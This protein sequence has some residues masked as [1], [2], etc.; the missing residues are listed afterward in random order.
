MRL[1]A[2]I[3]RRIGNLLRRER[4]ENQLAEELR[5]YVDE[6]AERKVRDGMA[7]GEARRQALIELGGLEQVKEEVRETWL[8]H[9]I[10]TL[11]RDAR[12][13]LRT[14]LR[15]PLFTAAA[16]ATLVLGIGA[17]TAIFSLVNATLLKPL[18]VRDPGTLIGCYARD[19]RKP[20]SYRACSYP[21]Y[22]GLRAL[23][24]VFSHLSAHTLVE[25]SVDAEGRTRHVVAD[26]VSSDYFDTLGVPLASG[27][28]F[29]AGEETPGGAVPSAIVSDAFRKK[30]GGGTGILGSTLRI[31]GRVFT[32]VGITRPGFTGATRLL[33]P[34]VYLPLG[35]YEAV[36]DSG[37]GRRL[38]ARDTR[39]LAMVGRL[40]PGMTGEAANRRLTVFSASMATLYPEHSR[41]L[42]GGVPSDVYVVGP[43]SRLGDSIDPGDNGAVMASSAILLC[44]SGAV[45][46]IAALNVAAMM[47]ARTTERRK[48]IA[49][50]LAIGAGRG[51][52]IAQLMTESLVLSLLGGIGALLAAEALTAA[53]QQSLA[54]VLPAEVELLFS[55]TFDPNVLMATLVFCLATTVVFGLGPAWQLSS[56]DLAPTLKNWAQTSAGKPRRLFSPPNLLVIGQLAMAVILLTVAVRQA[57]NAFQA[58]RVDTG[59]RVENVMVLQVDQP[60]APGW[61]GRRAQQVYRDLEAR[62]ADLPGV[63]STGISATL[64]FSGAAPSVSVRPFTA[65]PVLGES[66][67]KCRVN[68]VG[69]RYFPTLGVALLRGH[70]F[71][72]SRIQGDGPAVVMLD[73]AAATRLRPDGDVIGQ[74]VRIEA[75]EAQGLPEEAEVVGVVAN[76]RDE[77]TDTLP[78]PHI[79]GPF[80][81]QTPGERNIYL[82]LRSAD[83]GTAVFSERVREQVRAV[84]PSLAVRS[85]RTLRSRMDGG[86][87][88]WGIRA[89]SRLFGGMSAIAL[90]LAATGLY[91]VRSY[92]VARRTR[93]IGI[94]MALG[95]SVGG[96]VRMVLTEG[97]MITLIG[98]GLGGTI[99]IA[100]ERVLRSVSHGL[101]GSTLL[102]LGVALMV[103]SGVSV[104]ACL[105]PARQ[106]ARID[107]S[108]AFR[109][110]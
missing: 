64:P 91:A 56:P 74:R 10:A 29:T 33:G 15:R 40:R 83:V 106:A 89:R 104:L 23:P 78:A 14:L 34:D 109:S 16:V 26:L 12:Y 94:R 90:L 55:S 18:A 65:A 25:V 2:R 76:L 35:M 24:D 50:R 96:T 9:G 48:E 60:N 71:Q 4:L 44:L 95:A 86:L 37:G 100:T 87:S 42:G 62:L 8:G 101:G 43:L 21:D 20:D 82:K 17:N 3:K 22:S 110:E 28:A 93:E 1:A 70:E 52:V 84:D 66:D 69:A 72:A 53:L 68:F 38:E 99:A 6:M 79:Y 45:L 92:S 41:P 13:A 49:I 102:P 81:Q 27:R 46:L 98:S 88:M 54:R 59:M 30:I 7:H 57:G 103:L 58:A 80:G 97:L 105:I 85:L 61:D 73:K 75:G 31:A 32:I 19:S 51:R 67:L 11:A 39:A 63:M 47:L 77:P 36:D 5:A 107:P 108:I